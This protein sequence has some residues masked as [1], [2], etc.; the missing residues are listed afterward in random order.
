LLVSS[1]GMF[2]YLG[3]QKRSL[4]GQLT[5]Q[6][7][8]ATLSPTNKAFDA[9]QF[10]QLAYYSQLQ[11][12]AEANIREAAAQNQPND[13]E[14]F[15]VKLIAIGVIAYSYDIIWFTIYR[16]QL[17]ALLELNRRGGI[18]PIATI[19]AYYDQAVSDFS[20]EY[21]GSS[22]DA[23]LSFLSTNVLLFKHPSDMIEITIRGKD[24]LKYLLHHGRDAEQRRL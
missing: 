15:Y 18:L 19:R 6:S 24:F 2:V 11:P 21:A 10:F 16:S 20:S 17:L 5:V 7:T 8:T 22:F 3:R 14:G 9:T 23:W 1:A 12:E 4:S 13:K